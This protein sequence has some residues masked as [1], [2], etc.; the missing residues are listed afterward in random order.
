MTDLGPELGPLV[1]RLQH[2][3]FSTAAAR[4]RIAAAAR[5]RTRPGRSFAF[6]PR[7]TLAAAAMALL[8]VGVA[9]G[10]WTAGGAA[11]RAPVVAGRAGTAPV[12]TTAA[13]RGR[14]V[15]FALVAPDARRVSLVG[16]FN[17]WDPAATP[18][19]QVGDE[20]VIALPLTPGRHTYSFVV[21]D[22]EW[23]PDPAAPRDQAADFG[24][25]NSVV[26]VTSP[27]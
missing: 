1:E 27:L 25:P 6:I 3:D 5:A 2:E 7:L 21:D 20:W 24:L 10:R 14:A 22:G 9:I 17:E 16:D 12:M 15:R 8:A 11:P 18:L 4:A 23:I 13:D 19:T 26:Y